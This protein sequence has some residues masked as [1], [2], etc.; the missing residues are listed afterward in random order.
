MNFSRKTYF[1]TI[2]LLIGVA[3]IAYIGTRI[4]KPTVIP[5]IQ[6]DAVNT[7]PE[8]K[9]AATSTGPMMYGIPLEKPDPTLKPSFSVNDFPEWKL[10][11]RYDLAT[12][13]PDY[14]GLQNVQQMDL[15]SVAGY[16]PEYTDVTVKEYTIANVKNLNTYL[17][18]FAVSGEE[19]QLSYWLV[20]VQS[21]DRA[22]G[23]L[24][25]G[26]K[27]AFRI[28][29][30]FP[31]QL[32]LQPHIQDIIERAASLVVNEG[33]AVDAKSLEIPPP[34]NDNAQTNVKPALTKEIFESFHL[35]IVGALNNSEQ[36]GDP[37]LLEIQSTPLSTSEKSGWFTA[38]EYLIKNRDALMAEL[39]DPVLRIGNRSLYS[40]R[41]DGGMA[42][43]GKGLFLLNEHRALFVEEGLDDWNLETNPEILTFLKNVQLP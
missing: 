12:T 38:H 34:T 6:S 42:I 8:A 43:G 28:E 3:S 14:P 36:N 1:L 27:H 41:A 22:S 17:S 4:L 26:P 7:I 5:T 16:T 30:G 29:Q 10:Q 19:A 21:K 20:P 2:I 13:T 11:F 18:K 37:N 25:I 32:T 40:R 9:G 33:A 39:G 31:W 23:I 24:V 35:R 15:R